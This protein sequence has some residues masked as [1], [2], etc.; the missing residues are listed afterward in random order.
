MKALNTTNKAEIIFGDYEG[1]EKYAILMLYD[2][3]K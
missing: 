1:N 3:K 2:G